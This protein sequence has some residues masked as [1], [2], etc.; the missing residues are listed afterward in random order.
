MNKQPEVTFKVR[1]SGSFS[2]YFTLE[3]RHNGGF[4]LEFV[5]EAQD[6]IVVYIG[7]EQFNDLVKVVNRAKKYYDKFKGIEL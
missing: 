7:I 3:K 2:Q 4:A 6:P 5:R 1:E